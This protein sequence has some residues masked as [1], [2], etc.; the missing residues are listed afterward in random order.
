VG[1]SAHVT[2]VKFSHD[3]HYLISSGGA[4]TAVI[5][6]RNHG[7]KSGEESNTDQSDG[8]VGVASEDSALMNEDS[9]TDSEEEGKGWV[10]LL[11]KGTLY[12]K[13]LKLE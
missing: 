10:S 11:N 13:V 9:D 2:N 4:D 7:T 1:H 3:D 5:V 8:L 12:G 6:W